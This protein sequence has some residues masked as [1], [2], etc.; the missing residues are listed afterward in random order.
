MAQTLALGDDADTG[1]MRNFSHSV[2]LGAWTHGGSHS[3]WR[4][5]SKLSQFAAALAR[6]GL[7]ACRVWAHRAVLPDRKMTLC[8]FAFQPSSFSPIT[9]DP[10]PDSPPR[11]WLHLF[12]V[13]CTSIPAC[14][15]SF[16]LFKS[17]S[18]CAD[19]LPALVTVTGGCCNHLG[20][21]LSP[22]AA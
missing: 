19:S 20:T 4:T 9:K 7:H 22:K 3:P 14:T 1:A 15:S 13:H 12:P 10:H 8:F 17:I 6:Q 2:P 21:H 16:L 11:N 18:S 5:S